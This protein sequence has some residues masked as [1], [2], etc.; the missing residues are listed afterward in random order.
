MP[1]GSVTFS[2]LASGT[3]PISYAWYQGAT[4]LSGQ[5]S[6]TLTLTNV[7]A[8]NVGSYTAHLGSPRTVAAS[9]EVAF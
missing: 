4:L 5:T 8:A 1:A 7:G 6:A 9:M 3:A 2:T